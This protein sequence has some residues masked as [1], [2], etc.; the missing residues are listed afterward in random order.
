MWDIQVISH[1]MAFVI[2]LFPELTI[3]NPKKQRHKIKNL[4]IRFKLF[5]AAMIARLLGTRSLLTQNEAAS[6][7]VHSH[8]QSTAINDFGE[9]CMGTANI[10]TS[11]ALLAEN[12]W[13]TNGVCDE[14]QF[15]RFEGFLAELY[16]F[17][18]GESNNPYNLIET[19]GT[20]SNS[21][22]P[23]STDYTISLWRFLNICD[24]SCLQYRRLSNDNIKVVVDEKF[25]EYVMKAS[26]RFQF[27]GPD[28]SRFDMPKIVE[29]GS[30]TSFK[31]FEFRGQMIEQTIERSF[32]FN[33][34]NLEYV[35]HKSIV[36]FIES[37]LNKKINEHTAKYREEAKKKALKVRIAGR[38]DLSIKSEMLVKDFLP[39]SSSA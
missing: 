32:D 3:T 21:D 7:Y 23:S 1:E 36:T 39:V 17:L 26:T 28:G 5:N 11:M 24:L 25:I 34:D 18:S 31:Q 2:I 6:N 22:A 37:E 8:L 19:I 4:F 14:N 20:G 30:R 16:G 9:F 35:P 29:Y 13:V 27:M 10:R 12:P 15:E 33:L 38:R